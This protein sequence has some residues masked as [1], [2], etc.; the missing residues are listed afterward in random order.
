MFYCFFLF[1]RIIKLTKLPKKIVQGG[2]PMQ[3]KDLFSNAHA[4]VIHA[5]V[6]CSLG[7]K[8]THC[9]ND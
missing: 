2:E 6:T 5:N 1:Y 3:V 9:F 7:A 4:L 8:G